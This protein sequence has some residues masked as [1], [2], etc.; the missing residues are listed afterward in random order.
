MM[1]NLDFFPLRL[2]W[3]KQAAKRVVA[4]VPPSK[5]P[6][7]ALVEETKDEELAFYLSA[8]SLT[9]EEILAILKKYPDKNKLKFIREICPEKFEEV[10]QI[11][12]KC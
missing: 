7:E 8:K 2:F 1:P 3:G 6:Y 9:T 11:V 4:W 5:S 12:Q 10:K